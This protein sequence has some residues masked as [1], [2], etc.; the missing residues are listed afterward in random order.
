MTLLPTN[1]IV[2]AIRA[3][4]YAWLEPDNSQMAAALKQ[5]KP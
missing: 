1:D 2:V 3:A 4:A 5:L